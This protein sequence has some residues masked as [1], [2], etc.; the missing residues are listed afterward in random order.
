M[1]ERTSHRAAENDVADIINIIEAY[2]CDS[3]Q[4]LAQDQPQNSFRSIPKII[5]FCIRLY[6]VST[7][8]IQNLFI[9][10]KEK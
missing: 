10:Y 4:T 8:E 5:I 2:S 3:I 9:T 1:T 7:S 6:L